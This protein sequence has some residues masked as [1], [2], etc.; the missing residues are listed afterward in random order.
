MPVPLRLFVAALLATSPLQGQQCSDGPVALVLAGGGA[1]GFAH[2]GVLQSLDSLG[3]H[4]DLIV[5][6]SIGSIFGALY[7]SGLSGRQ[8]DSL[9][10]TLPAED[11]AGSFA[12]RSPH[13]WGALLPLLLWE[14]GRAGFSLVTRGASELR[15]NAVLNRT[16]LAGNLLARGDFDRLPIRFRAVATDLRTREAVALKDGDLAQAV[17]ASIAIPLVYTP[18]RIGDR[19]FIDGGISANLPIESARA[20]GARRLIVVDLKDDS[21]PTDSLDLTSPGAVAGRLAD[22]LFTQSAASLGPNDLY[23]RPDVRGFAN[24]DFRSNNRE[25]L[26]RN[27]RSAADS[28]LGRAGCFPRRS[29]PAVPALPVGLRGW[30]VVNGDAHDRETMGRVFGFAKGQRLELAAIGAQLSEAPNMET[31]REVWLGPVGD[32]DSVTFRASITPAARRVAGLGLA[33]DHDL[34][35]RLW[36]GALDRFS[37]RGLEGDAVLSLGRFKSDL[38]GTLLTHVGVGRMSLTP[39]ASFRLLS[40]GVRQ[41]TPDGT[42]FA[43]LESYEA[44]GFAG[45]EWARLGAWRIRAGGQ[46]ATWRTPEDEDRSTGGSFLSASFEPGRRVE[47]GAELTW[48]GHYQSVRATLGTSFGAGRLTLLPEVRLGAG[49]R[50]PLHKEF[51]LGGDEGFPGL[52]VGERR[53]DREVFARVQGSWTL[54]GRVALRMLVATGRSA[55]GGSLF[56]DSGWLAGIRTGLGATTPIGPVA[57]EYGFASNGRRA[58]FIRVGR[59]F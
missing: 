54:R 6:T 12:N 33:Y 55:T 49:R 20:A 30:D 29:A 38:T 1:K 34:G 9:A 52:H 31:F 39:V 16:L 57:F 18:E 48:T 32:A 59:W 45:V 50:L 17:R 26:V 15:T 44:A 51:E 24:L 42:N 23:I 35:G 25:R 4:P 19:Y 11:L 43:K 46:V 14:Q 8:I 53:G 36:I 22:F 10:R 27:G 40:E 3:L 2:I 13:N 28:I 47:G 37:G 7:A 58:A 56:E 5:G 21:P 41:F